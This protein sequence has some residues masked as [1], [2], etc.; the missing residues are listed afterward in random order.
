[1][2]AKQLREQ[3]EQLRLDAD[4][5]RKQAERFDYNARDYEKAEDKEKADLERIEAQKLLDQALVQEREADEHERSAADLD[6][7]ADSVAKERAALQAD[8]DRRMKELDSQEA[9]LRGG[10]GLFS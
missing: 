10:V 3:A 8:F 4:A 2:N 9:N 1:M 7:R 5:K 6:L